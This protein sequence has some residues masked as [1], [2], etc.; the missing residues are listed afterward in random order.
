ML[1]FI[2]KLLLLMGQ[3]LLKFFQNGRPKLHLIN[4]SLAEEYD[5]EFERLQRMLDEMAWYKAQEYDPHDR[6]DARNSFFY[7]HDPYDSHHSF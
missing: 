7:P 6:S 3:I 2:G 4:T 5:S 1:N